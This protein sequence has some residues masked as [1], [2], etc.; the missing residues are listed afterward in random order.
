MRSMRLLMAPA[1]VLVLLATGCVVLPPAVTEP[2][3]SVP[4]PTE[5]APSEPAPSDPAPSDPAPSDPSPSA[6]PSSEAPTVLAVQDGAC[7]PALLS[8]LLL[9]YDPATVQPAFTPAALLD[10]LEVACAATQASDVLP[11]VATHAIALVPL[12]DGIDLELDARILATGLV[13]DELVAGVYN[14]AVGD[15]IAFINTLEG[16][17]TT[18]PELGPY[19]DVDQWATVMW[20]A[21]P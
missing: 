17:I 3:P 10:G 13:P 4:A 18:Y 14:D 16:T 11:T 20:F 9:G 7:D 21:K 15:P 6:P 2:A 1:T 19:A 12:V 8:G 5:P